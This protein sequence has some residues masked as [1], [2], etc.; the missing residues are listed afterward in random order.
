LVNTLSFACCGVREATGSSARRA[1]NAPLERF[2]N[3][4]FKSCH[5]K[6]KKAPMEPFSFGRGD[7]I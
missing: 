2:H 5:T 4:L 3:A 6:R 1:K 7:R